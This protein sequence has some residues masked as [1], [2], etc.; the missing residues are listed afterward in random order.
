MNIQVNGNT[1][2]SL[3]KRYKATLKQASHITGIDEDKLNDWETN[4]TEMS[5]TQ[6][7]NYAK[8]FNAHWSVL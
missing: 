4:G 2:S 3:R 8:K 1:L 5:L 7:K 6:A